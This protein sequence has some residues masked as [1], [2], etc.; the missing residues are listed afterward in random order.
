MEY[1]Q[2]GNTSLMVSRL[3]FG[4]GPAGGHDYGPVD[5]AHWVSSVHAALDS[6]I[7]LF[8]VA[9]VYGLG[10]AEELLSE[11]LGQRRHDVV[12]A[13]K[14]GLVWDKHRKIHRDLRKATV[15]N[16]IESSLRRLRLDTVPLYQIHWPDPATPIEETLEALIECREQGKFKF[17]GVSNFP[18]HLVQQVHGILPIVSHQLAFNL[19][20]GE[21][22]SQ[23]FSWCTSSQISIVA[24]SGL[25]QGLLA[26]YRGLGQPLDANDVRNRSPYFS[27]A[28]REEKQAL[29]NA[30]RSL[31]GKLNRPFAAVSIRWILDNPAITSVLVGIKNSRQWKDN[32]DAIGWQMSSEDRDL[33][34]YLSSLCPGGLAGVPAHTSLA[35]HAR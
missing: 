16:S 27:E 31:S 6:G 9:D 2:L 4:S 1:R 14:G 26:G 35:S 13:T 20:C 12:I 28:D 33:L 5:K 10:L 32:V 23:M 15:V 22:E 18:L 30:V 8:D 25:A 19:L 21:P 34:S 17:L 29:L 3:G 11:A 24:H 7:N